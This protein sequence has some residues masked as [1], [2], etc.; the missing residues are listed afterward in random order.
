MYNEDKARLTPCK[1][2]LCKMTEN[3]QARCVQN[4]KYGLCAVLPKI[5]NTK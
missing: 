5:N 3:M 2:E 1:D 4:T